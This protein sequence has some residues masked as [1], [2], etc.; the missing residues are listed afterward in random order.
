MVEIHKAEQKKKKKRRRRTRNEDSLRDIW[1]NVK[2]P[3]FKS[4]MSQKKKTKGKGMRKYL[5]R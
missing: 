3:P 5:R 2:C 4:Q 1:D